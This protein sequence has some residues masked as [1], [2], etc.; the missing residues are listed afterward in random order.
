M[1]APTDPKLLER[2]AALQGMGESR[3][4]K[5]DA[6]FIQGKGN[7]VD[8]IKLPGMLHMDIVRSP[9]AHARIKNIDKSEAL[10]VPGVIAVLTAEDLKP[11]KLHW[12]PTLAGDVAAVLADG[13]VHFQMQE[14]AVVIAEDRYAAADGVEAVMVEYEDLPVVI[15]PYEALKPDA[16]VLREDLAGKTSG[17]HG[18]REHHNHIF[19][20]TAGDKEAADA[21]FANAPVTVAQHMHYPRVHP[22]PLETCGC[23]ASFDPVRGELTTYMTSQAPHVVRTVVSLLSGIPESK[24]RIVSPDIGG[25]FG[26]KVGIYPGYVCAIVSSIVLGRPVKWVEDRIENISSTAFARDY[27]MDGELAATAD[28]K[29]TALRVNVVADHGAFDACADPT[30]FPAGMFHIVSGSYDIPAAH[31]S[32]KGVYTNKAPGGVAYRCSFRVTEAVYLVERMVDVLAQKLGMDKAEIRAKN[33]IRKEQFPY[34]SAFGFEYDSGD[35]HTALKKVLDAVDYPAL[36]AEQAA[37]RADPHSPTL[38][39]I[40]L[41]TFTEVVGAGPS[42]MCDILGVGMFDSCEIRVHPT[43][44]ALA[45]MGT[46]T[47]GQGHQTTYAQ[48]IATELGIPSEVIQVEE[49][50]TSTAPYGLGTYGSRS[51]P[52]AGA[53]IAM[54]ARKIHAKARKIAAH[55]LEVGENDLDWEIDRF[56]VKGDPSRHKAM[57]DICWAAYNNVPPGMEMG[58]EAVHYYDPPNFTYPFGS[59]L[60]VVDIDRATG[61]TRVRRFYALDDCGT[62][63]NPMIIEGQI[64]G[65]LTEGYAVAMGQQMPFDAQGN[66]L[67]NTLM[68]YFLPTAVETPKWETDYTVTPSP[69]HPLGAKGVAE[70]PHVGSIPTFTAAVVDAFSHLGVTHMDMPHSAYRVW[71]QLKTSGVAL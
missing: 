13:K 7:Y 29:I 3:L 28:G 60:C 12:M 54:A 69:H 35:Y 14:V 19:T 62:R 38:M 8:D 67:G 21:A 52:V 59:Y 45:R 48:I 15:D 43:G 51:T 56:N 31:C 30:K 10:K 17:A 34:T 6:R 22:C 9:L 68:D 64:H 53:A 26:N 61:E 37:K 11:L 63:I 66:L 46:I 57:K 71:Q 24:V 41:V 50:D 27:H 32:V 5:E 65:G 20:W 47:Q 4:R 23:V 58:L 55:L 44:S 36:R 39:G 25:G 70:S 49:G 2:T 1:N 33:F 16:P 42:K 18:P 40:G